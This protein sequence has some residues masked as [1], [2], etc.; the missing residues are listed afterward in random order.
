MTILPNVM[1]M[2][3]INELN[4]MVPTVAPTSLGPTARARV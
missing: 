3:M 4:I 1:P 2:A